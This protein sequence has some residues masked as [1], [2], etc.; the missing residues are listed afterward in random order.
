[1]KTKIDSIFTTVLMLFGMLYSVLTF[2]WY[3]FPGKLTLDTMYFPAIALMYIFAGLFNLVRLKIK[4]QLIARLSI[5]VN[6]LLLIYAAYL[7]YLVKYAV[8]PYIATFVL[9]VVLICSITHL[10]NNKQPETVE[11]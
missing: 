4:H 8:P 9:A 5:T 3:V 2:T 6:L 11:I 7:T 1:M 10:E